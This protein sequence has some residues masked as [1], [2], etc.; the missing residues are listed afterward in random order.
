MIIKQMS[1]QYWCKDCGRVLCDKHRYQHTCEVIDAEKEKNSKMTIEE[2]RLRLE[3]DA[4]RKLA[5]EA[6]AEDEK[7]A[8]AEIVEGEKAIRK[9]RRKLIAGKAHS[10]ASFLQQCARDPDLERRPQFQK[11]LGELYTRA[12]RNALALYNE[13]ETP[14]GPELAETEWADVKEIYVRTRELTG[15]VLM[16]DGEP[17]SLRNPWD[18]PDPSDPGPAMDA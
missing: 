7:R 4:A 5:I 6:V 16:I 10:I 9:G 3:V 13:Y 14:S 8:A 12:N 1:D 15:V 17:L 2:L 18:P 11:E